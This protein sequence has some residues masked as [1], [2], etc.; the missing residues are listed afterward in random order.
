MVNQMGGEDAMGL[1]GTGVGLAVL[2]TGAAVAMKSMY[3]ITN[4]AGNRRPRRK[5][6][7]GRKSRR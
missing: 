7:K 6:Q 2:G 4:A 5:R 3:N 1:V